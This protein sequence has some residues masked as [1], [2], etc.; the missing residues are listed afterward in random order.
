[1]RFFACVLCMAAFTAANAYPFIGF[2]MKNVGGV[3][4]PNSTQCPDGNTCCPITSDQWG[5]CPVS[6]AVCCGDDKH[7]CPNGYTCAVSS[8]TCTKEAETI[9]VFKKQPALKNVTLKNIVCPDGGECPDGNTCCLSIVTSGLYGCCPYPN[10]VCCS[11]DEYC[12]PR[13]FKCN[14]GGK[15]EFEAEIIAAPGD[16]TYKMD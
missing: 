16:G 10:A 12:C 2:S 13:G 15:C 1:M 14:F 4:C 9:A 8:G 3:P 11:D 6:N 5:C 7:C